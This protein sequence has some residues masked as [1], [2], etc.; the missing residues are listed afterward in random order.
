MH[1]EKAGKE[2]SGNTLG[3]WLKKTSEFLA[4][5]KGLPV[6]IAVGLICFSLLLNVLPAWPVVGWLAQ[7][8]LFLHLGAILGLVGILIGDAL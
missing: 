4:H 2:K 3:N 7:T 8:D 6:L 1:P 5:H